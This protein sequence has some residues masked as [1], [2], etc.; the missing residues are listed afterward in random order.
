MKT[1]EDV[2]VADVSF[3][4]IELQQHYQNW[5]FL[6]SVKALTS[7][8]MVRLGQISPEVWDRVVDYMEFKFADLDFREEDIYIDW[9]IDAKFQ[10]TARELYE[11]YGTN[12]SFPFICWLLL[13]LFL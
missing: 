1:E 11:I 7:A 2:V 4:G 9:H 3:S 12:F 10:R 6:Q 13:V 5:N 8:R